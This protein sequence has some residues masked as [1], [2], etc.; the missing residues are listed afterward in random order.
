MI[1]FFT[2]LGFTVS[3]ISFE[4]NQTF[5]LASLEVTLTKLQVARQKTDAIIILQ[6]K[7]S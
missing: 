1:F 6:V 3:E 5:G 7:L 2:V 4:A